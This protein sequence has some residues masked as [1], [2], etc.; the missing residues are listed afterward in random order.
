MIKL[1]GVKMKRKGK[2]RDG[3]VERKNEAKEEEVR[4][5]STLRSSRRQCDCS[6]R[7]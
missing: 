3:Y 1:F 2:E 7:Y 6:R 5:A 4:K